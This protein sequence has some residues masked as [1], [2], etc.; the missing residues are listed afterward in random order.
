MGIISEDW[1]VNSKE[2]LSESEESPKISYSFKKE[3]ARSFS[4][5]AVILFIASEWS[6]SLMIVSLLLSLITSSF[7]NFT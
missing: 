2:S 1:I 3:D 7:V 4:K 5:A 6:F